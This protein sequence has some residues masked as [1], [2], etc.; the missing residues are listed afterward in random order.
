LSRRGG[1]ANGINTSEARGD[2]L[3]SNMRAKRAKLPIEPPK[4]KAGNPAWVKGGPS[5]NPKGRVPTGPT[6]RTLHARAQRDIL[7]KVK[8]DPLEFG[9][10][11]VLRDREM[12]AEMNVPLKSVTTGMRLAAF[13]SIAPYLYR[14]QPQLHEID[15]MLTQRQEHVLDAD[16]LKRLPVE[17]LDAAIALCEK[18]QALQS[19][20]VDVQP[21]SQREEEHDDA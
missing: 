17:D 7:L 6:E 4:R 16:A 19:D 3:A 15:A 10:A 21:N 11:L 9:V 5:P 1:D 20:V 13:N 18:I 12:L 14:R 2:M 8:H